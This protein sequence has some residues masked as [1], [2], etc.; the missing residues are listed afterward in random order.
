M[1]P[2]TTVQ[3]QALRSLLSLPILQ[4]IM[5]HN[6]YSFIHTKK[7]CVMRYRLTQDFFSIHFPLPL[8]TRQY[9]FTGFQKREIS[10]PGHQQNPA[11]RTASVTNFAGN[12]RRSPAGVLRS[13]GRSPPAASL[14]RP[15]IRGFPALEAPGANKPRQRPFSRLTGQGRAA[16]LPLCYPRLCSA[17]SY[18]AHAGAFCGKPSSRP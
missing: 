10:F 2:Q 8:S 14:A 18:R 6:P 9:F 15:A 11:S 17:R 13:A 1:T 3:L 12:R 5:S 7:S 4:S 16:A